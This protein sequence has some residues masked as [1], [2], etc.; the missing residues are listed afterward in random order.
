MHERGSDASGASLTERVDEVIERD[1]FAARD[2]RLAPS[3][4]VRSSSV[5]TS[6]SASS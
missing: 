2:L 5:S 1:E 3:T 4:A 6:S